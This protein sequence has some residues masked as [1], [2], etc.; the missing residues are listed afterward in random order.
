MPLLQCF[1]IWYSYFK[2]WYWKQHSKNQFLV[3]QS[4]NFYLPNWKY[5][6]PFL[7]TQDTFFKKLWFY[8]S[9]ATSFYHKDFW[10]KTFDNA[11]LNFYSFRINSFYKYYELNYNLYLLSLAGLYER[12]T[13]K[14][15]CLIIFLWIPL[16]IGLI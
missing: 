16:K 6:S 4:T 14:C 15:Q 3:N 2:L 11:F 1:E 7:Q 10:N 9:L 13:H 8:W 12:G 5:L